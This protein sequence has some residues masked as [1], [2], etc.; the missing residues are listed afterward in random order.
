VA[1]G[2]ADDATLKVREPS[3]TDAASRFLATAGAASKFEGDQSVG[4]E[5]LPSFS[6]TTEPGSEIVA[7]AVAVSESHDNEID[8][9]TGQACVSPAACSESCAAV[10]DV[11]DSKVRKAQNTKRSPLLVFCPFMHVHH[12]SFRPARLFFRFGFGSVLACNDCSSGD[13]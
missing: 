1:G 8:S 10:V 12:T 5:E 7:A 11:L 4:R 2:D 13:R 3:A 9:I 6:I